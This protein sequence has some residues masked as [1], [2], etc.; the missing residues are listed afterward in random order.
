MLVEDSAECICDDVSPMMLSAPFYRGSYTG[1][2]IPTGFGNTKY[3]K[4]LPALRACSARI[5][6]YIENGGKLLVF[7]AADSAPN[8]YDWL[9]FDI[10][11]HFEFGE[12][13]LEIDKTSKWS[14]MFDG[15]ETDNFA[16]D[17]WFEKYPGNP[18][19]VSKKNGKPILIECS[20]GCGT[21]ILS[22]AHEY[23]SCQMI[24]EL[25]AGED[26]RF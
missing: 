16:A 17:G 3:S 26:V 7:G 15:Y 21:L 25:A 2:I 14:C 23:P 11:Y 9:P 1:I 20:M 6:D 22:S 24:R 10:D 5:E 19:A 12:H 13:D 4:L 8:R 18:A